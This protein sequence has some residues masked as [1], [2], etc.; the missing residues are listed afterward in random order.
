MGGSFFTY[1]QLGFEHIIDP[2]GLDHFLFI[3][4][5]CAMYYPKDWRRITILVTAFTIGHSLTLLLAGRV[6]GI[7]PAD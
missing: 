7:L 4:G 6:G 3:I 2:A 1:L 5:L